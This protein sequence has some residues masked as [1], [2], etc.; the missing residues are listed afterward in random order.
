[1]EEWA[2]RRL[3][4]MPDEMAA[5]TA[6]ASNQANLTALK[7]EP[8]KAERPTQDEVEIAEVFVAPPPAAQPAR[9][10]APQTPASLPQT[11]SEYPL[12]G[13][14]GLGLLVGCVIAL[15]GRSEGLG[16]GG[17]AADAAAWAR[18]GAGRRE[19]ALGAGRQGIGIS[20]HTLRGRSA[21]GRRAPGSCGR[22]FRRWRA[23]RSALPRCGGPGRPWR[24]ANGSRRAV[25][26]GHPRNRPP[27]RG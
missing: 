18:R 24:G 1:M 2:R 11:G 27:R 6:T 26:R 8:L 23:S 12:A 14:I 25:P 10:P 20:S 3:P 13:L 9:Q 15:R 4:A 16:A 22:R 21:S 5:K 19:C 7:Q 17:A